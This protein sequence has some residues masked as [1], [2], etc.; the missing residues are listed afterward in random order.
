[1]CVISLCL[2]FILNISLL[3]HPSSQPPPSYHPSLLHSWRRS[4]QTSPV[5]HLFSCP[6]PPSDLSLL[7]SWPCP[8]QPSPLGHPSLRLPHS[9][10]ASLLRYWTR[11]SQS[12]RLCHRV[13]LPSHSCYPSLLRSWLHPPQSLQLFLCHPPS[14]DHSLL[15]SRPCPQQPSLCHAPVLHSHYRASLLRSWSVPL[16]PSHLRH[17]SL[18][19]LH[20]HHCSFPQS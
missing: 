17:L 2:A 20:S 7:H 9:Y 6:L 1:M 15:H 10:H 18:S 14:S 19:R 13:L 8:P 16:P 12:S 11:P 3:C 4:L 5:C